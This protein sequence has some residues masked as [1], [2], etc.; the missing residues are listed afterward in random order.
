MGRVQTDESKFSLEL[1]Y[2]KH[3]FLCG[4]SSC[5]GDLVLVILVPFAVP[6]GSTTLSLGPKLVLFIRYHVLFKAIIIII[7]INRRRSRREG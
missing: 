1:D 4:S 6:S 3:K 7:I 5:G 2:I